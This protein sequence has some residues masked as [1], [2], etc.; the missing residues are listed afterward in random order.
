[1]DEGVEKTGEGEMLCRADSEGV[2]VACSVGDF[3]LQVG[4]GARSSGI[5]AQADLWRAQPSATH[6]TLVPYSFLRN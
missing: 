6:F 3:K 2:G 1:M 4:I 5:P